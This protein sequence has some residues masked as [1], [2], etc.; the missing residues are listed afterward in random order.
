[1]TAVCTADLATEIDEAH[2]AEL[3]QMRSGSVIGAA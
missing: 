1:M 2:V 3:P